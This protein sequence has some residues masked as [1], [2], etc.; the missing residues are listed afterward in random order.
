MK[1]HHI[2]YLVEDIQSAIQQFMQM[3]YHL[4]K[5]GVV[6]DDARGISICFMES[7]GLLVELIS[8][9]G[10]KSTVSGMLKKKGPG[11]YHICYLSENLNADISLL[12]KTG[13]MPIT[14][15][16]PAIALQNKKVA[17]LFSKNAG[18]IELLEK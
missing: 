18:I 3:G 16:A 13:F 11:P 14:P 7:G 6:Q 15:P 17:F 1:A 4:Q 12:S 10:G 2:G 9:L 5:D 8:P